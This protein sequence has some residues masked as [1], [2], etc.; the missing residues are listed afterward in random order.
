MLAQDV[1]S[2][3][4]PEQINA[5]H[6][7]S[8]VVEQRAGDVVYSQGEPGKYLYVLLD[9]QVTLRLPGKKG[10]SIL[11]ETVGRG[12]MFGAGASL[13]PRPYTLTAQCLAD[14]KVLRIETALLRRLMDEDC[15]MGYALQKRVSDVYFKRYIETM[16]KLQ[17]IVTSIPL[18][19][20]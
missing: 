4:R 18:E 8:E 13:E 9:G 20:Q 11:I 7:A 6:N 3:L 1:F 15:R 14:S 19:A 17:A 2:Y 10:L 16:Q 5:I 12:A